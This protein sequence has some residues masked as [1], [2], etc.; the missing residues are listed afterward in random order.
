MSDEP[1]DKPREPAWVT[2]LARLGIAA[3]RVKGDKRRQQSSGAASEGRRLVAWSCRCGWQG[4]AKDL[5]AG[6][7]GLACPACGAGDGLTSA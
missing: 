6:A 3:E 5:K 7:G 2:R 1:E 4:G